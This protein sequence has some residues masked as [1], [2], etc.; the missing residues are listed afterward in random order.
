M[1]YEGQG[2]QT[3]KSFEAQEALNNDHLLEIT[4]WLIL[5]ILH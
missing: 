4:N 2:N 3:L 1:V 5:I